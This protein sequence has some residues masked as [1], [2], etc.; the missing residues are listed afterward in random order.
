MKTIPATR[1]NSAATTAHTL[2]LGEYRLTYLPDG[3]VQLDPRAW[4][5]EA[6]PDHW[7]ALAGELLDGAGFLS[8][9]IGALLVEYRGRCLLIDAGFG[10]YDIPAAHTHPSLGRLAG[11]GLA[12][13]I[14]AA[15]RTPAD[16]EAVAFTHLHD[17]HFGWALSRD[18]P[19][20][21]LLASA[22]LIASTPEWASWPT[23]PTTGIRRVGDGE[24][25]FPGV[26]AWL[27]PGH[28]PGHTC[29][30]ISAGAQRLVAFGDVFHTPAQL[31]NPHWRVT[32]DARP[33]AGVDTRR[34]VLTEL[35]R[36]GT[37]AF[38]NHFAD[39]PFGQLTADGSSYNWEP[40]T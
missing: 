26:T 39:V 18:R 27:T 9:S 3:A 20:P 1:W 7:S 33:E 10:P 19:R 4:F 37:L 40:L 15:G 17:D 6:G 13:S 23:R 24:E 16:I 5:P 21:A 14:E 31:A 30:V 2:R 35:A 11:G 25:I 12:A 29:Y 32:M 8:A 34:A 22:T 38:A 28:T 36:P